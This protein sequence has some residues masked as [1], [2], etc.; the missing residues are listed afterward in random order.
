[1]DQPICGQYLSRIQ[2]KAAPSEIA[3][4]ATPFSDEKNPCS[5]IPWLESHFPKTIQ[6]THGNIAEIQGCRT[7]PTHALRGENKAAKMVDV[8]LLVL[9]N[10]IGEARG[11]EALIKAPS[12]G[13]GDSSAVEEGPTPSGSGKRLI[14]HW[15]TDHAKCGLPLNGQTD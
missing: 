11:N 15:I 2:S 12:P 8:V 1:M 7:A 3:H 4:S 13:D 5:K 10:V 14:S 6:S 9:P